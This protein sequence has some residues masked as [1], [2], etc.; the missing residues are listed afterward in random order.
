MES[1]TPIKSRWLLIV[2]VTCGDVPGGWWESEGFRPT[3]PE[4]NEETRGWDEIPE[5]EVKA[6]DLTQDWVRGDAIIA[7]TQEEADGIG[8]EIAER[9]GARSWHVSYLDDETDEE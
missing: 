4:G 2:G 8:A 7:A 3:D 6:R 1:N 5:E 9:V